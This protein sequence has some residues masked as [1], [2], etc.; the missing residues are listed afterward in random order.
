[1]AGGRIVVVR[2]SCPAKKSEVEQ[3][4]RNEQVCKRG[5]CMQWI[6]IAG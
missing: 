5:R 6:P 2:F 1:M 4:D 3:N